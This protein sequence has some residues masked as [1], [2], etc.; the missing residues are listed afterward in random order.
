MLYTISCLY[1][2]NPKEKKFCHAR[3]SGSTD[4]YDHEAIKPC[5]VPREFM[6]RNPTDFCDISN[7]MSIYNP[8]GGI[9]YVA[10]CIYPEVITPRGTI[11]RHKIP[12]TI[13]VS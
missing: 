13:D 7:E 12:R 10:K 6:G 3:L 5:R 4:T 8:E 1:H 9:I 11:R 2:H